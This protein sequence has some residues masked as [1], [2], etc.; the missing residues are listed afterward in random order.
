MAKIITKKGKVIE[1]IDRCTFKV[2]YDEKVVTV[3]LGKGIESHLEKIIDIGDE[4]IFQMS[5]YDLS[6]GRI[7]RYTFRGGFG[8]Q[9]ID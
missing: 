1:L 9:I 5:P 4:V 8:D 2:Q 7:H 3:Y 6:R